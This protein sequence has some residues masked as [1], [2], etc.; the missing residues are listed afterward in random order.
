MGDLYEVL[1]LIGEGNFARVHRGRRRY[2]GQSCAL[3]FLK[4]QGKAPEELAAIRSELSIL[5][6]LHHPNIVALLDTYE[7]E[8]D[9]VLV[10]EL[11]VGELF[12]VLT[13]DG[14]LPAAVVGSVARDLVGALAYL[15][16]SKVMHRD[17]KPQNCL[18][19]SAG[20]IKLC[21]F[22]FARELGSRTS[23]LLTSLKGT[24]LY[25]APEIFLTKKYLP[26]ADVWGLGVLVFELASG[27]PPFYADT[28]PDLMQAIV[29]DSPSAYPEGM[30]PGLRAF[31]QECLVRDPTQRATW[32]RLQAHPFL[33]LPP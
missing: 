14:A 7:T 16:A 29:E 12:E 23:A 26:S 15:H 11:A 9:L 10:T 24:P 17:L 31:L 27:R 28:L 13:S 6:R 22:G 5:S 1:E 4:K 25:M 21:D 8:S 3:K 2:T 18:I 33:A 20:V 19:T 32:D 30:N